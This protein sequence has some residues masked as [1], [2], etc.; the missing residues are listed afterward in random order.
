ME[1]KEDQNSGAHLTKAKQAAYRLLKVR[2]RSEKEIAERLLLKKFSVEAIQQTISFLKE[3]K[4]LDDRQFVK[5]W[6]ADRLSK[7][8]GIKR[9]VFELKKKGISDDHISE[10]VESIKQN[11]N[12]E[13]IVHDIIRRKIIQYK[14]P[15]RQKRKKRLFDYLI[16]RGFSPEIIDKAIARL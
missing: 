7:P 2:C 8:Y 6:V 9:I 14:D 12:E 15:D 16:Y 13:A 11:I 4:L 10:A 1:T 5:V 3:A